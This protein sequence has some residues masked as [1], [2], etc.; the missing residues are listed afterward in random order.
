MGQT[1]ERIRTDIQT[2]RLRLR[3]PVA[4]DAAAIAALAGDFDVTRMTARMPHPLSTHRCRGLYQ[5][6]RTVRLFRQP[7]LGH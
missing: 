4:A 7:D 5:P 2:Q 6:C 3:T 1:F